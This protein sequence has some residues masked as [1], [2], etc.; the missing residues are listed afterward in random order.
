MPEFTQD[1]RARLVRI[2]KKLNA[3]GRAM[4]GPA[5]KTAWAEAEADLPASQQT[6]R[7]RA[8]GCWTGIAGRRAPHEPGCEAA[9]R[10]AQ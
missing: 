4:G 10:A 6:F 8:C 1:D 5:L 7:R 2:E 3:L 9:T